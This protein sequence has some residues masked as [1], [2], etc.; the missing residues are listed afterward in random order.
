MK[1]YT[2]KQFQIMT[3][4]D[5]VWDLM[6][7]VFRPDGS[8][9]QFAP[10]FEY[11]AAGSWLNKELMYLD[12][13][14]LFE[15]TPAAFVFYEQPVSRLFFV[16]REGHEVLA[17]EMIAYAEEAFPVYDE[18]KCLVF[19]PGQQALLRAAER[20]GWHKNS[21]E[22]WYAFDFGKGKLDFPLPEGFRFVKPAESDPLKVA[23]CL[24]D[25]FNSEEL[26]HFVDWDVPAS[27]GGRSP[28]ELY[29]SVLRCSSAPPPHATYED[30]VIIANEEG[31]YVCFSG[32]WWVEKNKL[33]YM[34]PLCTV[35]EY[36]HRGLAAAALSEH[37]RR[38][39][40]RGAVIMTGGGNEFYRRIGYQ[41][42]LR[43]L[44]YVK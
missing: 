33:A 1:G 16:L 7:D 9:G 32:M 38:L 6:T 8:T 42:E 18:P 27:N 21:E 5:L 37:D 22:V 13:F 41:V 35:P 25:G 2:T 4:M 3:D 26:G 11:A 23:K 30:E 10:F 12:R 36:Q 39:R 31:E 40:P 19:S 17:D 24:W 15:D 14:W 29:Q 28:Y 43:E 20:R 44:Y 34:E